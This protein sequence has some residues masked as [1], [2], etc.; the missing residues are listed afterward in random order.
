VNAT[1]YKGY[2]PRQTPAERAD[3]ALRLAMAGKEYHAW[4][5]E[6]REFYRN[7][8]ARVRENRD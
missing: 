4:R 3:R 5:K 8:L 1:R 7:L 6:R 2:A